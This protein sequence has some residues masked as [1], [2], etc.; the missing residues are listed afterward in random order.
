MGVVVQTVAA[1]QQE[2]PVKETQG[3]H[4]VALEEQEA[5]PQE[6]QVLVYKVGQD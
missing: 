1:A 6:R 4:R 3:L 2:Q 5:G